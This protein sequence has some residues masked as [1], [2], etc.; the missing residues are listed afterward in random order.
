MPGLLETHVEE[1]TLAGAVS[2][3][4][5]GSEQIGKRDRT[6]GIVDNSLSF[7][8]LGKK[9]GIMYGRGMVLEVHLTAKDYFSLLAYRMRTGYQSV[10]IIMS[11]MHSLGVAREPCEVRQSC[12]EHSEHCVLGYF[13]GSGSG[14]GKSLRLM[15][16]VRSWTRFCWGWLVLLNPTQGHR[17]FDRADSVLEGRFVG[18]VRRSLTYQL[19]NASSLWQVVLHPLGL[20][21]LFSQVKK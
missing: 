11:E 13:I 9:E 1:Y 3:H 7:S 17:R 16:H 6:E 14:S 4:T 10:N 15:P 5:Q 19:G 21:V 20:P 8:T 2:H 18:L 12:W